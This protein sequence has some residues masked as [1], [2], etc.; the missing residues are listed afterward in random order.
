MYP[1]AVALL[2]LG[3]LSLLSFTCA[4]H[5]KTRGN[6]CPVGKSSDSH[7][8]VNQ[9][10]PKSWPYQVYKSAPFNP[11]ELQI[12][13]NGQH[14]APGLLFFAQETFSTPNLKDIAPMIMT[15]QGQLIWNGPRVNATNFRVTTLNDKPILTYWSGVSTAVPNVGHG[16]GNVTILDSSYKTLAVIC[17]QLGLVT[18]DN[19]K[20]QCEG[21]FHESRITD[22]GTI[23]VSAYNATQADLSSL[24]GPKEGWVFDCLFFELDLTGKILFKWS[25]L[26]HVSVADSKYPLLGTG[27]NQS[28]PFDFFHINTAVIVG[29]DQ[30]LI[31][32]RHLWTTYL[33]DSQGKILWTLQGDNGGDFGEIPEKGKFVSL[34]P[35]PV[36]ANEQRYSDFITVLAARRSAL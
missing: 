2:P 36:E 27:H 19:I 4:S 13:G 28:S 8:V 12:K 21:D 18:P 1:S 32:S 20:Y 30:F 25:A 31:N 6:S 33:L 23:L 3:V 26:E 16:Y 24:G 5:K 22:R 17:P 34:W 15:D 9:T 11:P 7:T 29:K 10:G 14:L 35:I